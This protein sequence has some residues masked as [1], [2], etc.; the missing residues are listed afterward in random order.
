MHSLTLKWYQLFSVD[1][2]QF[3]HMKAMNGAV[4]DKLRRRIHNDGI[5][6]VVQSTK[7]HTGLFLDL[8]GND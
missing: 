2:Q 5:I 3:V 1:L 4:D 8:F 6:F 7:S